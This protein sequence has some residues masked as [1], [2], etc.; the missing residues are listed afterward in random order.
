MIR[1]EGE[2]I[3]ALGF[4][5][6]W[7]GNLLEFEGPLITLQEDL[8]EKG[9][10]YLY[11]WVDADL[12]GNRWAVIPLAP[13]ILDRFLFGEITLREL[14]FAPAEVYLIDLDESLQAVQVLRLRPGALPNDYLPEEDSYFGENAYSAFAVEL[15]DERARA[16]P[17]TDDPDRKI[18]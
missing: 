1:V 3:E 15:R 9:A 16:G 6:Q 12:H 18:L 4:E 8:A 13:G 17:P 11:K 14:S 10:Q 2:R 5:T 7:L